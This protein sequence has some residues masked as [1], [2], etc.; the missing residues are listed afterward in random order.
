MD[1]EV[2]ARFTDITDTDLDNQITNILALTPYSG[3]CY[4]R[5]SLKAGSIHVQRSQVRESLCRVDPIGRNM[6]QRYAICRRVYSVPGPNYLW[7][8]D[9]NHK[10]ISWRFVLH[11]CIDGFS[12]AI[13]YLEC[14]LDNTAETVVELFRNGIQEFGLPSRVRGDRGEC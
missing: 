2:E 10:L 7:H 11:G 4:V 5:G 1:Y 12:R 3:E 9:S 13:I 6:Q 8:I 14:K